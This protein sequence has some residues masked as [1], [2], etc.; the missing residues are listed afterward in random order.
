MKQMDDYQSENK[1][2]LE[3]FGNNITKNVNV[4]SFETKRALESYK[5]NLDRNIEK[6]NQNFGNV[7]GKLQNYI[8]RFETY[9]KTKIEPAYIN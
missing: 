2:F 5:D 9:S 6:F 4:L 1:E 3:K 8:D 7:D